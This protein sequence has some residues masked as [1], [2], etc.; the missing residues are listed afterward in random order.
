MVFWR[1][2]VYPK[3]GTSKLYVFKENS[4]DVSMFDILDKKELK[5]KIE[6]KVRAVS[7]TICAQDKIF[8]I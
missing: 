8:V 6:N 7:R 3:T 2:K 5:M 4:N 1:L